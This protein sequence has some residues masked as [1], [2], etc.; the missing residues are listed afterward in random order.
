MTVV[1]P[2]LFRKK[3]RN[4]S[5]TDKNEKKSNYAY[6]LPAVDN[7]SNGAV[8]QKKGLQALLKQECPQATTGKTSG[9]RS[10]IDKCCHMFGV[11]K[12]LF[13]SDGCLVTTVIYYFCIGIQIIYVLYAIENTWRSEMMLLGLQ[14][15]LFSSSSL[16]V[17]TSYAKVLFK[18]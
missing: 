18:N 8:A 11:M 5:R 13:P 3:R 16:F 14:L 4:R 17:V 6:T 9:R 15:V 2:K 12:R 7:G 1:L 10:S